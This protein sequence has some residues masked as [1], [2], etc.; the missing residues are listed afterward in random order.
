L[1]YKQYHMVNEV[2]SKWVIMAKICNRKTAD[3][4]YVYILR[5]A[6]NSLYTGVTVDIN[7]RIHEHNN[8]VSQGAKYTRTRRPVKLVY[9]EILKSRAMA[10]KRECEIKGL[11]RMGKENL[12]RNFQPGR[13]K[14]RPL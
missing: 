6:D 7:R 4:W 10:L 3:T 14:N 11:K 8:H 13:R 1:L 2:P 5:C 12:I 9:E